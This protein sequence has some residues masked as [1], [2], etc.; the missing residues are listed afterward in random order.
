MLL[1][2]LPL[3]SL[4]MPL[5]LATSGAKLG[6]PL[7]LQ[8]LHLSM[9]LMI[10]RKSSRHDKLGGRCRSIFTEAK[11]EQLEICNVHSNSLLMTKLSKFCPP[12]TFTK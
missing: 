2:N 10:V 12:Q 4:K 9:K 8:I 5:L 7:P 3:L 11:I 1:T 6:S